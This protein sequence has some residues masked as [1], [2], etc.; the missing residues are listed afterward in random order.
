MQGI[1]KD[2]RCQAALPI[3]KGGFG[4]TPNEC[5]ATPAFYSAVS[6]ALRF[7]AA[8]DFKPIQS[9]IQS[10]EFLPHPLLLA[11]DKARSDLLQC[12]ALEPGQEDAT[13]QPPL[14]QMR[15]PLAGDRGNAQKKQNSAPVLPKIE[16][17]LTHRAIGP[18]LHFLAHSTVPECA[19]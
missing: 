11:Y 3:A 16:D 18:P 10:E 8:S 2:T 17:V 4:I 13:S 6:K 12:G 7:A 9:Y 15:A 14:P 19:T 5:V 1:F